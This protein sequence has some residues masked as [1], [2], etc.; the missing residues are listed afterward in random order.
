M[1]FCPCSWKTAVHPCHPRCASCRLQATRHIPPAPEARPL[2]KR[3]PASH[4][5][6][7]GVQVAQCDR[8]RRQDVTYAAV[9]DPTLCRRARS[10][11]ARHPRGIYVLA[12]PWGAPRLLAAA[13]A[14]CPA[15]SPFPH[16][17]RPISFAF[18]LLPPPALG[19]VRTLLRLASDFGASYPG[20]PL[21]A[22]RVPRFSLRRLH[23]SG[24][25]A[26][27]GRARPAT[28]PPSE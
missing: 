24:V 6:P 25:R 27:C 19:R 22:R 11:S 20:A 13:L 12:Y 2:A 5:K 3:D 10:M 4:P 9:I 15:W 8:C 14:S 1:Q 18:P 23:L 7:C 28:Q 26:S 21:L 17:G 16:C